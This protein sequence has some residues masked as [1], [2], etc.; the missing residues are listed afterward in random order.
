MCTGNCLTPES[1]TFTYLLADASTKEA[2][3][4]DPVLEQVPPLPSLPAVLSKSP[5]LQQHIMLAG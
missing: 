5:L 1:S 3:L 2:L 4:I